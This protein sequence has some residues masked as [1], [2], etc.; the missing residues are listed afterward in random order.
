M[1]IIGIVF[2]V[3][4]R[5]IHAM[6]Q[7]SKTAQQEEAMYNAVTLMGAI[8][9]LSWDNNNTV[10]DQILQVNQIN[11][12]YECNTTS[13]YRIGGF[14]GGRNCIEPSGVDYNATGL[15]LEGTDMND[16]DDYTIDINASSECSRNNGK[17]LYT[18]TP[19]IRYVNDPSSTGAI[20]LSDVNISNTSNT[21]HVIVKVGYHSDNKLTGCITALQYD[22]FNIG[23]IHINSRSW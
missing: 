9:N 13:G 12:P 5:L 17:S 20:T 2:T 14:I 16:I 23:Q 18:L 6:N 21:K 10:N 7:T 19:I 1:V 8:I 15:G 3:I 4:P 22:A 11:S